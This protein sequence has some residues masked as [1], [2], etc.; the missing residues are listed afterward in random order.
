VLDIPVWQLIA[1]EPD[2][3]RRRADWVR[4]QAQGASGREDVDVVA[5]E[6]PVG[7]GSLP[8]QVLPSFGVSVPASSPAR[9]AAALRRGP[10][11]ILA[12]I[13]DDAIVFDLRT[14]AP[15]EDGT[16]A[17]RIADVPPPRR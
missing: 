15:F 12:R 13:L 11:R 10:D 5:L 1:R 2:E 17:R 6:S 8:G 4:G 3:L 16:V 7:G 9:A 14:V